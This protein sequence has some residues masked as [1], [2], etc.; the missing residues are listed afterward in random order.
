MPSGRLFIPGCFKKDRWCPFGGDGSY[1]EIS[2]FLE[3]DFDKIQELKTFIN[4]IG[5]IGPFSVEF[6]H[7]NGK[8]YFFEINLR[9]D[10]T[11]HY[12]HKAGIYI[13]FFF[14]QDSLNKYCSPSVIKTKYFFIDEFS[15]FYNVLFGKVSFTRWLRDLRAAKVYKYY[16]SQDKIVF[17]DLF[18]KKIMADFYHFCR[19]VFFKK[20]RQGNN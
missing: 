14:Y 3:E 9:N 7:S 19:I 10:G 18:L 11:S 15:D 12:F 13:P 6:G 17:Y 8:D 5:Y 16:H 1:G 2:T 20:K 4:K